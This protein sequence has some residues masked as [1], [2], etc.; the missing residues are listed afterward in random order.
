MRVLV[1]E[2]EPLLAMLLE[3]NLAE[4]GHDLV[5]SAATVEQALAVLESEQVDCALLDYSLG[6]EMNSLEIA[7]RLQSNGRPFYFLTGHKHLSFDLPID[8]P[9]LEKP[10]TLDQ[11]QRALAAMDRAAQTTAY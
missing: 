6:H 9:M 4:L 7:E 3:D 2:D 1:V 5:G 8:A 10:V 11:L